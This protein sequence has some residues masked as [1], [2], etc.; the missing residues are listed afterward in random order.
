MNLIKRIMI[1]LGVTVIVLLGVQLGNLHDY[2]KAADSNQEF[3]KN[4]ISKINTSQNNL[5]FVLIHG[6]WADVSFFDETAAA[7]R[8]QGHTVYVPE[9]PGHGVLNK[10]KNVTHEQITNA[11]V[12][13]IKKKDLKNIVLLG[14]SFGG[15]VIMT[16]SQQT[17]DRIRRLVFFNAFVPLNGESL[18]DQLPPPI[19]ETFGK[20]SQASGDGTILLPFPLFRDAFANTASLEEAK[21]LYSKV[22][23]EP[24]RPLEQ[25]LDLKKFYELQIPKSYLNLTEDTALPH[26][27]YAWHPKQSSH[28]GFFRY[29]EG[30]GD[31][32]TTVHT[33]PRMIAEKFV[34]AGR[35]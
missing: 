5:T 2:A 18:Y 29:I 25:K 15:T 28:L 7:L 24:A 34:E 35:D 30:D 11:V 23:P 3:P 20:L 21:A 19:K 33:E 17:P 14:H 6:S 4:E 12:D 13:Y 31:H 10:D 22:K 9:L 16:V 1:P 27:D 8:K 26:G 32:F